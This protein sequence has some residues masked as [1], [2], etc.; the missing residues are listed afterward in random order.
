MRV[1]LAFG[2]K[3]FER[4]WTLTIP[5]K[6]D[7]DGDGLIVD[8]LNADWLERNEGVLVGLS[9]ESMEYRLEGSK[10]ADAVGRAGVVVFSWHSPL[11]IET[12]SMAMWL[13]TDPAIPSNVT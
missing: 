7:E 11:V 6:T 13:A 2:I 4:I 1:Y 8:D 12:S 3:A 9:V 5:D 10:D